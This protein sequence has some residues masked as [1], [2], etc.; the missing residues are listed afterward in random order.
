MLRIR[1]VS[2]LGVKAVEDGAVY[3]PDVPVADHVKLLG[4]REIAGFGVSGDVMLNVAV[5]WSRENHPHRYAFRAGGQICPVTVTVWLMSIWV[6]SM[7][8]VMQGP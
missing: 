4:P 8:A 5:I 1:R 7:L 6:R 3:G 2:D